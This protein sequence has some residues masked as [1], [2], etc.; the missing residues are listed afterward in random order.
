MVFETSDGYFRGIPAMN[1]WGN[2]VVRNIF[3]K[4]AL[5]DDIT[6]FIVLDLE[7]DIAIIS[8]EYV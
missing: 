8:C 4:E 5:L 3:L 6:R 7:L 2:K 1:M